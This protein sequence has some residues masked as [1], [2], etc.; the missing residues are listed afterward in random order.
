M[1]A[2]APIEQAMIGHMTG[3]PAWMISHMRAE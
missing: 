1:I 2:A 3:P